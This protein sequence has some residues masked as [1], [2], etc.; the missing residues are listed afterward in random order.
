M[1]VG[2]GSCTASRDPPRRALTLESIHLS[3]DLSRAFTREVRSRAREFLV[4]AY[5]GLA[6]SCSR[7]ALWTSLLAACFNDPYLDGYV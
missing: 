7:A 5:V 1:S 3:P 2:G 6:A 4:R